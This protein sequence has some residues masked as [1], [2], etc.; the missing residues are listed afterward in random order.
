MRKLVDG[1][2]LADLVEVHS[3]GTANWHRGEP[4]DER[5]RDEASKRG[6]TLDSRASTFLPGDAA[7]YDLVLAMDRSNERDLRER[8]D[9]SL[10]GRIH[11]LRSF[12]P[13]LGST[14]RW[15]GE[16]PDP[17]S[18]GEE[19]FAEVFDLIEAACRGLLAEIEQS[20]DNR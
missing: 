20:L 4:P 5:A 1:A 11:L 8:T 15:D 19:G 16:V 10:H 17:W 9:S 12:D 13:T 2:G 7:F 3:A 18:G 6:V 14:D